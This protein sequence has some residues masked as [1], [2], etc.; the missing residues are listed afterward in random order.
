MMKR[1]E[2]LLS[3]SALDSSSECANL[4]VQTAKVA[5]MQASFMLKSTFGRA[6][7]AELRNRLDPCTYERVGAPR[8]AR[9]HLCVQSLAAAFYF[10]YRTFERF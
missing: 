8:G 9:R 3:S 5:S 10:C 6:G 4:T 2:A 1:K 7:T